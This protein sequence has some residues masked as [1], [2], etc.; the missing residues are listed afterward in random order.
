MNGTLANYT[1]EDGIQLLCE[2]SED[3]NVNRPSTLVLSFLGH[4]YNL[5]VI[6]YA[7]CFYV[8][9]QWKQLEVTENKLNIEF[10]PSQVG[11]QKIEIEILHLTKRI[12]YCVIYVD[13]K[14]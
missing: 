7:E 13:I 9:V 1:M 6:P 12:G 14:S 4:T 10:V 11:R 2:F 8:N 3:W 5:T